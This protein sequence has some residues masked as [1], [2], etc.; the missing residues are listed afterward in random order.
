MYKKASLDITL[1]EFKDK[2]M[3][4][5][6]NINLDSTELHMHIGGPL[7]SI[8]K[9]VEGVEDKIVTTETN[10]THS[11]IVIIKKAL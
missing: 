5:P 3:T 10:K 8:M 4:D 7:I 9:E 1:K 6:S 2:L 11:L